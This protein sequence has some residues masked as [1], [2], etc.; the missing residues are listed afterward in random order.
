M[1]ILAKIKD[2]AVAQFE[3]GERYGETIFFLLAAEVG[4]VVREHLVMSIKSKKITDVF[5]PRSYVSSNLF[6]NGIHKKG[7]KSKM[8]VVA[9]INESS[10]VVHLEEL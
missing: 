5:G 3:Q 4:K 6:Y 2:F 1:F 9:L 8:F 7:T 10:N